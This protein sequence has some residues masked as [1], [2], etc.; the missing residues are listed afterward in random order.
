MKKYLVLAMIPTL[1]LCSISD[2]AYADELDH[3]GSFSSGHF[4]SV[5][6]ENPDPDVCFYLGT[7]DNP[8]DCSTAAA[9]Q[10]YPH[11]T[12]RR[13]TYSYKNF[14]R[15]KFGSYETLACFGCMQ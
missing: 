1:S 7:A 4:W 2:M 3:G 5:E 14:S 8:G 10:G 15:G 13:A 6:G 11:Y 9:Q 12:V